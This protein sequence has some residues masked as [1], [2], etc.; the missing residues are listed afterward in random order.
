M[1]Q[2]EPVSAPTLAPSRGGDIR[3]P[4]RLGV[5]INVIRPACFRGDERLRCRD[6]ACAWRRECC[7]LV[8]EWKR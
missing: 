8:A 2:P 5:T 4:R 1:A 6:R 7:R 3:D